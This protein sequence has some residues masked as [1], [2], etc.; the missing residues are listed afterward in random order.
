[1]I[2][3]IS[4]ASSTR[5]TQQLEYLVL[6]L[7]ETQHRCFLFYESICMRYWKTWY[8][9][10]CLRKT[11]IAFCVISKVD[12]LIVDL[13]TQ[14]ILPYISEYPYLHVYGIT[15]ISADI[16]QSSKRKISKIMEKYAHRHYSVCKTGHNLFEEF[17]QMVRNA[18]GMFGWNWGYQKHLSSR[19]SNKKVSKKCKYYLSGGIWAITVMDK[20][21]LQNLCCYFLLF[22]AKQCDAYFQKI[23]R[24]LWQKPAKSVTKHLYH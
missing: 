16:C 3:Y 23:N 2:W 1:M 11:V 9:Q 19:E 13:Q 5:C 15:E 10:I 21:T 20:Q 14:T 24:F 18:E 22:S 8:S 6:L 12:Y 4:L 17:W 7:E